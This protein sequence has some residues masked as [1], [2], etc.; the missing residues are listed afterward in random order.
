[1]TSRRVWWRLRSPLSRLFTELFIHR[2]KK[3]SKLLVTGLRVGNSPVTGEFPA[4]RASNAETIYILWRHHELPLNAMKTLP[5]LVVIRVVIYKKNASDQKLSYD[6]LNCRCYSFFLRL[7]E[8]PCLTIDQLFG[9]TEYNYSHLVVGSSLLIIGLCR[10]FS[11][12]DR[13]IRLSISCYAESHV[14]QGMG[15]VHTHTHI[16]IYT[17]I[18]VLF[19]IKIFIRHEI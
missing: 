9:V 3:T 10:R 4:Q 5:Y 6:T 18:S 17:E 16:Y 11:S 15:N 12:L 19:C 14:S 7:P 2:S 8:S 1:M 13:I